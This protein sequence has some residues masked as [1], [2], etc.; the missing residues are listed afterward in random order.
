M[1][2]QEMMQRSNEVDG[3]IHFPLLQHHQ[4]PKYHHDVAQNS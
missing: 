4:E 1:Q 2:L 3:M